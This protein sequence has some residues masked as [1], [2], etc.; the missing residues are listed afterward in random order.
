MELTAPRLPELLVGPVLTLRRWRAE[1]VPAL[2]VAVER[3]VG[4]A[5][6]QT[7]APVVE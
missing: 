5:F 3:N 6:S 4:W 2:S 7:L 1:D